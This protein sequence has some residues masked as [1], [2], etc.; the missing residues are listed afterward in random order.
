MGRFLCNND[1]K[2]VEKN[3]TVTAKYVQDKKKA[4]KKLTLEVQLG[5]KDRHIMRYF[6]LIVGTN[7]IKN[8]ALS[9]KVIIIVLKIESVILQIKVDKQLTN[10]T[11]PVRSTLFNQRVVMVLKE[12]QNTLICCVSTVRTRPKKICVMNA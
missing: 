3:I 8:C 11:N 7:L 4:E 9:A 10:L 2:T 12:N 6:V 5:R 1:A